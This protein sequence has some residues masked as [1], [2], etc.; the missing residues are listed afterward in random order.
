MRGYAGA[1][2]VA[3]VDGRADLVPGLGFRVE[4]LVFRV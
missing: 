1:L 2:V 3:A 4:D